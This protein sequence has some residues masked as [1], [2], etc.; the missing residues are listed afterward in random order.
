MGVIK[1]RSKLDNENSIISSIN[2]FKLLS[3]GFPIMNLI[4]I[5]GSLI[6]GKLTLLYINDFHQGHI[7]SNLI[8]YLFYNVLP[9][10]VIV[11]IIKS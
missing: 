7:M 2:S 1:Q 9:C 4:C 6:S 5:S 10:C 3:P 11:I 8:A